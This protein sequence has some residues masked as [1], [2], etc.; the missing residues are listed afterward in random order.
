MTASSPRV[1]LF[2]VDAAGAY[3]VPSGVG[4]RSLEVWQWL[5]SHSMTTPDPGLHLAIHGLPQKDGSRQTLVV[6]LEQV[7]ALIAA[8]TAAAM[9]LSA[10]DFGDVMPD[11]QRTEQ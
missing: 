6:K 8:L 2:T 4:D 11:S 3:H 9:D 5:D 1:P 7:P 10:A